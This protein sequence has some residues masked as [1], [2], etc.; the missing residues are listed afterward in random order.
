MVAEP[1]TRGATGQATGAPP[2]PKAGVVPGGQGRGTDSREGPPSNHKVS[3]VSAGSRE[4]SERCGPPP[5]PHTPTPQ[6]EL[7]HPPREG[8]GRWLCAWT[9]Q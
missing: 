9:W 3:R 7:F 4:G 5:H 8:K 1:R 6:P 2:T